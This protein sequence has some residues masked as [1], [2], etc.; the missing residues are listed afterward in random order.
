MI[1]GKDLEDM[2]YFDQFDLNKPDDS[3]VLADY[4]DWVENKIVTIGDERLIENT[5]GL[6][7][8]AGEVAEKVKKKIRDRNKISAEEIVKELGDVL[9]YVTALAN[10]F[11]DNLAI[12]MEKNVAKLDDREKRGT[13]KGSGDNR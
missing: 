7:G 12:V 3:T 10:Y 2:G 6:V 4:S 13:I 9:F 5:L 1:T 11:G 8:E